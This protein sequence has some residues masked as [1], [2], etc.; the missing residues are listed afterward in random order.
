[1]QKYRIIYLTRYLPKAQ[2]A[3]PLS[4]ML[5]YT[6]DSALDHRDDVQPVN[7]LVISRM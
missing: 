5:R 7:R 4:P 3:L 6:H 2:P 1:M